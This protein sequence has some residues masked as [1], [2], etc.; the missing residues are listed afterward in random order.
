[1]HACYDLQRCPPTYDAVAFLALLDLLRVQLK[2][3]D[4]HIH[5]L[6][7]PAG[8]FRRDN[9]W[10]RDL[11]ERVHVRDNVLVPLCH[12]LPSVREVTVET[13][14]DFEGWGKTEYHVGL[15]NILA[16]LRHGSRPLRAAA[17]PR[18]EDERVVTFTLREAAHHPL[19]N[20]RTDEWLEAAKVLRERNGLR[21]IVVRDTAVGFAPVPGVEVFAAPEELHR[22]AGLYASAHLN[23]GVSNGPMWMSVFMNAST[24]MLRPTTNEAGGCYDDAF[25]ATCGIRR[26]EQLPGD[27]PHQRLVWGED[28]CDNIVASVEEMLA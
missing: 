5:V 10:P 8:G 6:P 12:L 24:L 2:E 21:V 18:Q 13:T 1:M 15:R 11:A 27:A 25:Y 20:S 14:R 4:V 16:A 7:G 23:V 22:R 26:G 28:Y 17:H 19:R 3:D 9:L